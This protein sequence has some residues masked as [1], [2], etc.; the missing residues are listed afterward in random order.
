MK[1]IILLFYFLFPWLTSGQ[2]LVPNPDFES[3]IACPEN[4]GELDSLTDWFNPALNNTI[5]SPDYFNQCSIYPVVSVPGHSSGYQVPHSGNGYVGIFQYYFL[6]PDYR[7]YIECQL[8][9][10]LAKDTCY[11]FGM[12]INLQNICMYSSN[13]IGVYFSDTAIINVMNGGPLPFTPQISYSGPMPDTLNWIYFSG[14]FTADGG[15]KYIIIGNFSNDS[16]TNLAQQSGFGAPYA[17]CYIDDVSLMSCQLTGIPENKTTP[18]ISISAGTLSINPHSEKITFS[19]FDISGQILKQ[20]DV[21]T[22]EN[23]NIRDLADGI[24]FYSIFSESGKK[25]SGKLMITN[26]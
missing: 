8:S 23:I 4:A 15:E 1:R 9:G 25:S 21:N 19:L 5:S 20:I 12:Y 10:T 7:E 18:E 13:S 2:N 11:E 24:Y 16:T 6:S 3:Y 14:N 22:D 17:Y 26:Y